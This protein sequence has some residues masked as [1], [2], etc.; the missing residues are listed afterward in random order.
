MDVKGTRQSLV[1]ALY[2]NVPDL[3]NKDF[4]PVFQEDIQF[5]YTGRLN[6]EM[7][8]WHSR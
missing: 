1:L 2:R 4:N 5:P 7:N 8:Q 6:E 3:M